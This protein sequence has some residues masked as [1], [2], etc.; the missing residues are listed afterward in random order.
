MI[1][2]W[3]HN[4]CCYVAVSWHFSQPTVRFQPNSILI[5]IAILIVAVYGVNILGQKSVFVIVCQS[6]L[7][8]NSL[9]QIFWT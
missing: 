8:F 7:T 2:F 3:D 5:Y 6:L 4:V 1:S 9:N